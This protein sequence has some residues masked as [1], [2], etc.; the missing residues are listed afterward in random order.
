M[1]PAVDSTTIPIPANERAVQEN[2]SV[3]EIGER[4]TKLIETAIQLH[5]SDGKTIMSLLARKR[6]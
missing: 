4:L 6:G 1:F 5:G 2:P 3:M